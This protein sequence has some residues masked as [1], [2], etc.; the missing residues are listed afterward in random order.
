MSLRDAW[1]EQAEAWVTWARTPDHDVFFWRY[2]LPSFL[3]LVPVP[4]RRTLDVGCGEGRLGR[5]LE[6]QGHRMVGI[7]SSPTLVSAAAHHDAA[8]PVGVG[9]AAALPVGG[10][11]VDLVVAFMSLQDVDDLDG[12]MHEIARVLVPTGRLCL[13]IIHPMVSVGE[14][15]DPDD[16]TADFVIRRPYPVHEHLVELFE[17]NGLSM[18]FHTMHRPLSAYTSALER[19]G[20]VLESVREPIPDDEL[21]RDVPRMARQQRVPWF[22]HLRAVKS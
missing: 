19:A 13:A 9:D 6:A 2:N 8:Y 16:L 10:G 1:E 12:V 7:D 18:V 20:F 5:I 4:G 3:E 15:A 21:V 14:F 17:R 11:E 22:L